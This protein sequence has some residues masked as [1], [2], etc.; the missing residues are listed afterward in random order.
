MANRHGL[1]TGATGT[2]KTVTLQKM[3]EGFSAIGVPVF[4]ADVK[5]DLSGHQPGRADDAQAQGAARLAQAARA[6]VRRLPGHVLGRVRRAGPLRCAP[7]SRRWARCCSSRMLESERHA[8]RRADPGVQDRRRQRPAAARSQ[9]PAR[10]A[11]VRRRQR[12]SSSPPQYGN[13]STASIGAIQRGL[14]ALEQQGARQ[15]LRR[16]GAQRRRPD[17][18][19]QAAAA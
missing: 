10:D 12:A 3:A 17:A 11:A 6:A 15:I 16:A 9:G 5:G 18:D 1:I 4:M 13:V 2:G 19:R 8:G 7:R 14:L